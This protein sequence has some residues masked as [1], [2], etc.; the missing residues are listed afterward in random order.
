MSDT[1]KFILNTTED[2]IRQG[3]YNGF[4]FRNIADAIGIKSSSVHYHFETKEKLGAAT[5]KRYTE[6]FLIFLGE[7]EQ[8]KDQGINPVVHYVAAFRGAITSDNG[9][10]LC[11]ILGTE[12]NM[13]PES[14]VAELNNFFDKN[15]QW[16]ERAYEQI[17]V[18][19]AE[20]RHKKALQTLSLLEGAMMISI[21]KKDI[22]FFDTAIQIVLDAAERLN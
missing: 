8:L 11:G 1:E 19:G 4:S 12:A 18:S 21:S 7:P 16:L 9:M 13:L 3:G 20:E 5:T 6:N 10:C 17:G 2:M 22:D 15:V 14:I